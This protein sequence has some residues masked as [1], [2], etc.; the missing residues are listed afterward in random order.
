MSS[1]L[2]AGSDDLHGHFDDVLLREAELLEELS[3]RC[4]STEALHADRRTVEADVAAPAEARER[5]DRDAR[6]DILRQDALLILLTLLLEEVHARH[7]DDADDDAALAELFLCLDGQGNL[8][9]LSL[10]PG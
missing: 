10:H 2:F 4:R 7:R 6:T 8:G 3:G 5:L 1:F 9:A